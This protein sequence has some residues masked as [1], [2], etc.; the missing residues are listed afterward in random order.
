[1]ET[2]LFPTV[3]FYCVHAA[4]GTLYCHTMSDSSLPLLQPENPAELGGKIYEMMGMAL[5]GKWTTPA[6][7]Q[8]ATVPQPGLSGNQDVVEAEFVEPSEAGQK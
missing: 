6:G 2:S 8:Q 3:S 7:G 5:A 4:T 1:M